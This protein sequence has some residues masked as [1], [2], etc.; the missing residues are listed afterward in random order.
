MVRGGYLNGYWRN[1]ALIFEPTKLKRM[2]IVNGDIMIRSVILQI[3]F[4]SF[5]FLGASFGDITLAAN[6]VLLQFLYITSYAMDGFATAAEALVGQ[7]MGAR[8]RPALRRAVVMTSQW[9]AVLIVLLA[10]VFAVFGY[11]LI[12]VMTT[13]HDVRMVAAQ[14]L[15]WMIA[16]PLLGGAS[17]ML[18][19]IFIGATRSRDMRNM[20]IVSFGIYAVSLAVLMPAFG[21][22]GLWAA[23]IIF[24][25]MRGIT[26]AIRYPK[27]EASV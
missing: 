12:D 7:A 6:Q 15:P 27:L 18:D 13:S 5:L 4:V 14:Y 25:V 11:A 1:W 2:A 17:W 9:A 20:M 23:M 21:N 10:L 24:F 22:H 26:L 8:A 3:G 16:A 19:G